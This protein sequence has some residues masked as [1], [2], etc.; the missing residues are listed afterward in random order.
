MA[1]VITYERPSEQ[2]DTQVATLNVGVK[3]STFEQ[4]ET[5]IKDMRK[6][7]MSHCTAEL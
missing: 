1:R 3:Y 6:R 2:V 7:I 5:A 4:L